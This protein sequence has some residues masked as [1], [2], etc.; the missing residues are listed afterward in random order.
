MSRFFPSLRVPA[1]PS[2]GS[3]S[4]KL[5]LGAGLV[6]RV[7]WWLNPTNVIVFLIIPLFSFAAYF[8]RFN[9]WLFNSRQDFV[10]AG[11]F[12]LGLYSAVLLLIGIGLTKLAGPY[13]IIVSE[14]QEH[15]ANRVLFMVGAITIAA[16]LVLLGTL[17]FEFSLVFALLRGQVGAPEELR[18]VLGRIPGLSSFIQF[19]IVYLAAVAALRA[20]AGYRLTPT[21]WVMWWMILGL[22]LLRAVLASE[23]LAFLEA[24]AAVLVVPMAYSW[25]PSTIKTYAPF[26]AGMFVFAGFA[27]GEYV[28]SWQWYQQ[29]FDSYFEFIVQRFSGYYS[30]S[31][32]NGAGAYLMFGADSPTPEITVGWVT[33]FPGLAQ[34]F[35]SEQDTLLYRYLTT[36]G[37]PE[38]NNP[39]GLYAAFLDYNFFGAS[40]FMLLLGV[41]I[42]V[43]HRSFRS[44]R[45]L[46]LILYPAFV[47][48]LSDLIRLIWF[49]DTRAFP[50]FVGAF[51][52]AWALAPREVRLQAAPAPEGAVC[53]T[54]GRRQAQYRR[55]GI[56]PRT[57]RG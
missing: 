46:G 20:L 51:A 3:G 38:F 41:L 11:T 40:L 35:V 7:P 13:E 15:R 57:T 55:V 4:G 28:R 36:Y 5:L 50:V 45:I 53:G 25:R 24:L 30:T 54:S 2:Y 12:A 44:R 32:N 34:F 37:T 23:R 52:V 49:S 22:T 31:V 8:N 14:I 26:F 33:R 43:I 9:F 1:S 48:G 29:F 16:Y 27:A 18:E 6:Q 19:G 39:G 21:L 47:V 10:T 17:L 42:G 56:A